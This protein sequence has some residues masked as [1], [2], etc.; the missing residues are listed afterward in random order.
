[1]IV[2][3]YPAAKKIPDQTFSIFFDCSLGLHWIS[4]QSF[5]AIET[6][7]L[8]QNWWRISIKFTFLWWIFCLSC[9]CK[10]PVGC[11]CLKAYKLLHVW[12]PTLAGIENLA[13]S[14]TCLLVSWPQF[15]T[16]FALF[17]IKTLICRLRFR[18]GLTKYKNKTHTR[19][20]Q[21]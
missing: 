2:T 12:I 4:Y 11:F 21:M 17:S 1:M 15:L 3:F 7:W 9:T 6:R 8:G 5:I 14:S 13:I 20:S 18:P 10:L 16:F 19:T